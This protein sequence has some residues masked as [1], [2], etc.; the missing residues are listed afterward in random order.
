MY[1]KHHKV[2]KQR[3][4]Y[5]RWKESDPEHYARVQ[6]ERMRRLNRRGKLEVLAHYGKGKKVKCCWHGCK[7]IDPD[8]LTLDHIRNDGYKEHEGLRGGGA[9]MKRTLQ[10]QNWP[11]WFQTLC[12]NHQWKKEILRRMKERKP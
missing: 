5:K 3:A 2:K 8:M 9:E 4:A 12:W 10:K 11:E 6:R 1:A 7:I